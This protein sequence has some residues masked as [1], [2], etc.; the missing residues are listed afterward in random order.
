[1]AATAPERRARIE[2]RLRERLAALHV[3]VVDESAQH[4][5]HAGAAGGGGHFRAVIVAAAF[6]GKSLVERQRLVYGALAE[7][8]QGEIHA[9][10][11]QTLTPEQWNARSA[12]PVR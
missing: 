4:A 9:L 12:P 5:G 7:M 11:M 2:S 1:M 8:M 3:A 6:E 10:A